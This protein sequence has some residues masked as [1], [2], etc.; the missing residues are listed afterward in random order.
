MTTAILIKQLQDLVENQEE[1]EVKIAD[2]NGELFDI[3]NIGFDEDKQ[4]VVLS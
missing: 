3:L 4:C 2:D 1:L